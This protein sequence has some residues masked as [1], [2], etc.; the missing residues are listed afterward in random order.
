VRWKWHKGVTCGITLSKILDISL[1]NLIVKRENVIIYDEAKR[2]VC[3]QI[4]LSQEYFEKI[5][6]GRMR[7][8]QKKK[9]VQVWNFVD[10]IF[11]MKFQGA[12]EM[13]FPW[14]ISC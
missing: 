14:K 9:R 2:A 8:N 11:S 13:D 12:R 7:T 10:K 5:E 3:I 6:E 1:I 4:N